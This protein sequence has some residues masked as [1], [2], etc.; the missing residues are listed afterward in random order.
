MKGFGYDGCAVLNTQLR[1]GAERQHQPQEEAVEADTADSW[2]FSA[3]VP[4]LCRDSD[5]R[6]VYSTGVCS[7]VACPKERFVGDIGFA[8]QIADWLTRLSSVSFC[9]RLTLHTRRCGQPRR[10]MARVDW[11]SIFRRNDD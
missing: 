3:F 6:D 4:Q 8:G 10:G 7:S 1:G 5:L 11:E 9:L 2:T